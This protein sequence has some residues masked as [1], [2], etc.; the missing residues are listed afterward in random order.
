MNAIPK[1]WYKNAPV[2]IIS[3]KLVKQQFQFKKGNFELVR[4]AD[5]AIRYQCTYK[6]TQEPVIIHT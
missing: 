1:N 4:S 5:I 6:G 3:M 2:E